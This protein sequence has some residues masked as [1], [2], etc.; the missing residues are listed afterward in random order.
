MK[1]K[2]PSFHGPWCHLEDAGE[3]KENHAQYGCYLN[4][5]I[6]NVVICFMHISMLVFGH[7]WVHCAQKKVIFMLVRVD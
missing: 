5:C 7:V 2:G 3:K 4:D 6:V 1:I